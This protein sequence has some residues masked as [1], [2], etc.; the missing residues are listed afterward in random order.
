MGLARQ[1][2]GRICAELRIMGPRCLGT[3]IAC[4]GSRHSSSQSP[5]TCA[6]VSPGP[7]ATS[8]PSRTPLGTLER[9]LRAAAQW[10]RWVFTECAQH[11]LQSYLREPQSAPPTATA[12]LQ[13]RG[14]TVWRQEAPITDWLI[15]VTPQC[16]LEGWKW[17]KSRVCKTVIVPKTGWID[18]FG[19][20]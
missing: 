9:R 3:P 20:F 14:A 15:L 2:G 7:P 4:A 19:R 17:G 5:R 13:T 6:S 10:A 11:R 18:V 16:W 1:C 12:E 8:P